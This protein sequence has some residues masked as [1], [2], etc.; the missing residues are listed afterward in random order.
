ML[1]EIDRHPELADEEHG[2]AA[3]V[4]RQDHGAV[5]AVVD[6]AHLLFDHA[7]ATREVESDFPKP[8][9][10]VGEELVRADFYEGGQGDLVGK[11]DRAGGLP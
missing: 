7:V 8:P 5:A 10:I 1:V 2:A 3:G 4:D 9:P 11:R 6:L